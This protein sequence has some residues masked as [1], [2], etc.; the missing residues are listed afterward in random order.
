MSE[1]LKIRSLT[2]KDRTVFTGMLLKF[3][4]EIG[5]DNLL[6]IMSAS[7]GA[8]TDKGAAAESKTDYAVI[9]IEILQKMIVA[10]E[11]D[12]SVW[13]ASLAGKTIDEYD[14]L[15]LTTE[16]EIME[17]LVDAPE[18]KDFFAAA[19]RLSS[20]IQGFQNIMKNQSPK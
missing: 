6:K 2:R 14:E 17:Q 1:S 15:P 18:I 5:N 13:F 8:A 7:M 20:K 4:K 11:S 16:I 9:G 19:L 3:V 10:I 12:V